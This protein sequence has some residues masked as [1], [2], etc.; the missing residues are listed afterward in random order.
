MVFIHQ[1]KIKVQG[2]LVWIE[3]LQLSSVVSFF[4]SAHTYRRPAAKDRQEEK[5]KGKN[6]P[7]TVCL[8]ASSGTRPARAT[9]RHRRG[10]PRWIHATGGRGHVAPSI[11]DAL[12]SGGVCPRGLSAAFRGARE[13][14]AHSG[15]TLPPHPHHHH[16]PDSKQGHVNGTSGTR[17]P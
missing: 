12:I 13:A 9:H 14:A 11:P 17:L 10:S 8:V 1:L 15:L 7:L 16:H 4:I 5:R 6:S 2:F 3:T